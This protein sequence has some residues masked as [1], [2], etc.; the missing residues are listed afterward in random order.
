MGLKYHGLLVESENSGQLRFG[1]D[2]LLGSCLYW[3]WNTKKEVPD[4]VQTVVKRFNN[5]V[6]TQCV[7]K[8]R[9]SVFKIDKA[10]LN[11][12]TAIDIF[13]RKD[14]YL[15]NGSTVEQI[16][17]YLNTQSEI[18]Y[19]LDSLLSYIRILA[20]CLA[21]SIPF[22]YS[23]AKNISNR[24]F[25]DHR[26]WFL[27]TRS[28]FDLEYNEILLSRTRWFDLLAGENPKGVRDSIIHNFATYQLGFTRKTG[29]KAN[30]FINLVTSEGISDPK[31]YFTI[32]TIL[33][34][35]FEYLDSIYF[36]FGQ[37]IIE[38]MKFPLIKSFELSSVLMNYSDFKNLSTRYRLYP[39]I[40]E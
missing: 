38:E 17:K 31:L 9:D 6:Y 35:F 16:N 4:S 34:D 3:I 23:S 30:I 14:E 29:K 40:S 13:E 1:I 19:H 8:F 22:F 20:D 39:Q 2:K 15:K 36:L 21:F 5:K 11:L 28:N 10:I 25:N 27:K 26:K 7:A 33:A 24:S 18:P 12:S 32:T 37:R